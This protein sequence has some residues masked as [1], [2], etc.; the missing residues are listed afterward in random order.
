MT[1]S[2]DSQFL[3][4]D[5]AALIFSPLKFRHLE[6]KN[7]LLRSSISGTFDDYNGHGT[8]ARLN[9]EEKFARGGIGAII[10][11]FVPVTPRGR[12]LPRY[13]MIDDDDKIPFWR[14]VGKRI[15]AFDCKFL[16][17]LSHS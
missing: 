13:A 16:M 12:I 3:H 2:S 17:Q 9:W 7:R 1:L 11:S 15:H 4:E 14:E 6:V 10:S 8:Q 5:N